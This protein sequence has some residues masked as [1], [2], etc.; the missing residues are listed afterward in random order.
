M[1]LSFWCICECVYLIMHYWPII[2]V[3]LSVENRNVYEI[4]FFSSVFFPFRTEFWENRMETRE[5]NLL[6]HWVINII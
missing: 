3:M 5:K 1:N 6:A 4:I 2:V